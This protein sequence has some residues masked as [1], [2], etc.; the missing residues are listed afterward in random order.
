MTDSESAPT[1]DPKNAAGTTAPSDA[2]ARQAEAAW[3]ARVRANNT[4]AERFRE[5]AP[6]DDFYAPVASVFRA[7]PT[8]TDD[9]ALNALLAI[10]RPDDTWLDVGA[11]GGRYSLG[12]ARVVNRVIAVEPSEAMRAVFRETADEFGIDNAE[13][14]DV[15]WPPPDPAAFRADVAF[16]S[17]VGYDVAEI[18]P[19]L[20]ALEASA[21]R[22]CAALLMSPSPIATF[23][24]LW[25]DLH[26]EP[27][28]ELPGLRE[29]MALLLARGALPEMQLVT[30]HSWRFD[31]RADAE[32]AALRR[33]WLAPEGAKAD[34]LRAALAASLLPDPTADSPDG[35]RVP[36]H[37]RVGLVTWTPAAHEHH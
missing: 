16:I 14:R 20:D 21:S 34:R 27:Q 5:E 6:R 28:A 35:V 23:A 8:R 18:G 33:L 7:D 9:P 2:A 31:S 15:R 26:G 30:T 22:T 24:P 1:A 12:V 10:A 19:F 25:P 4:Q 37:S 13:L 17:H 3:T 32:A 11:G 29:F 36:H